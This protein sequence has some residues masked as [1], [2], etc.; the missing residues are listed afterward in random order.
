[1]NSLGE[2]DENGIKEY[3]SKLIQ[4][5]QVNTLQEVFNLALLSSNTLQAVTVAREPNLS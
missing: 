5:F 3:Y 2:L 4:K 1:M